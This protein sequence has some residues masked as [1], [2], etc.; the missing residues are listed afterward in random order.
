ELR[1]VRCCPVH[2]RDVWARAHAV[3]GGLGGVEPATWPFTGPRAE[4]LRHKPRQCGGRWLVDGAKE[5]PFRRPPSTV[6][7]PPICRPRYRAGRAG[8][9]RACRAPARLHRES[10]G[11]VEP[12]G[13]G[14]AD[15]WSAA[16]LSP[17]PTRPLAVSRPAEGEGV[18]PSRHRCSAVFETAAIAEVWLAL[19]VIQSLRG[20]IR[21]CALLLPRQAR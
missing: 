21:T 7:R 20:R 9:M 12:P 6:H 14:F 17:L 1:S 15:R 2:H 10:A 13:C 18:E 4:A 19:P 5:L 8:L 16:P 3:R 11:G